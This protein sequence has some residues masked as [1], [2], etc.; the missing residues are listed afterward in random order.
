MEATGRA[1]TTQIGEI[2][3]AAH[4]GSSVIDSTTR[5]FVAE[6]AVVKRSI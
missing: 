6:H 3:A 1:L 4:E 2:A 5:H